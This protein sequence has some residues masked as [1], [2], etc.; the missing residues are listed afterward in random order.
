M[1]RWK[2]VWADLWKNKTRTFL[3][4]LSIA[5][6][7][8][9]VGLVVSSFVIVKR[10]MERD[11]QAI[12]PHTFQIFCREFDQDMLHGLADTPGVTALE[13]RYNLWIKIAGADGQEYP[14]NL[15]SIGPLD[16]MQVDKLVFQQGTTTLGYRE[17]YLERQGAEGLGV[18]PGDYVDLIL[19]TGKIRTLKVAG[20]VH[21]VMANPFRFTSSTAGFV[22]PKTMEWLGESSQFNFVTV[23]TSGPQTDIPYI[24]TIAEEVAK[25]IER[26]GH[27]V[28]N[29]NI[30]NPGQHPAQPIINTVQMLMS[31][32]GVMSV[33]LSVFLIINTTT[34]LMGQQ[35]RQIG[36]MKAIGA[37]TFQ[38]IGMYLALVLAFGL[39]AL[40]IAIPLAGLAASVLTRW[41]VGMLNADPSPFFIPPISLWLQV[42]IALGVPMVAALFP[43]LGGTRLTIRQ[44]ISDY[45][46]SARGSRNLF[47]RLL[48]SIHGLPR[49]LLLSLRNTFSRKVRL[50]FTLVT[51]ILGGAIFIAVVSVRAS[52]RIETERSFG[53]YHSDVNVEFANPVLL[54]RAL[55]AIKDIPGIVVVEGWNI[56]K[57]NV[58]RSDDENSDQVALYAPPADTQLVNPTLAEGRWLLPADT[59]AIVVDNHFI[60]IR[61][62]VNVG[63][64]ISLRIGEKE[65]PF[66]VVGIFRLASNVPNPFVFVNNDYLVKRIG[67]RSAV[68]NLRVMTAF[69][70]TAFQTNVRQ[71]LQASFDTRNIQVTMQTGGESIANSR[72]QTDILIYLLLFMAVLIAMVGGLGLSGTMSMNVLERTR[73]IGVMRSIGAESGMIFQMVVVEGLLIGLM[74]WVLSIP[75]AI[76]LTH[77]LDDRLGSQLMTLPLNYTLSVPGIFIWLVIVLLLAAIA[78]FLPA[79][80][81]I[82]LTVRDVLAYE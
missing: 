54:P 56:L 3:A 53:Y 12:N 51:L 72:R 20:T 68:T 37:T 15:N 48:E 41:L 57:V 76:P 43:V 64:T 61:P 31:A 16:E 45:G 62:D 8:F 67:D 52:I 21:D 70:D 13:A 19:S 60:K 73:E 17:I 29:I 9:A 33:L 47:D 77:L 25:R 23:S 36:V 38:L 4:A 55:D 50:V 27:R 26:S 18:E 34:A 14:I 49:P 82:R 74:S 42:C 1:I 63:D 44:A 2:K 75:L 11:Y 7:V 35:T 79:R 65:Y 80:N 5:V 39:L 22:T 32:L 28:L 71:A 81:A 24:R 58:M 46:L 59:N 10:D 6:G 69:H 30:N 40:L 78:S 66:V